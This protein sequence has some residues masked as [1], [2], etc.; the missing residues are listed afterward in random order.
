MHLVGELI[1]STALPL[2]WH[3]SD[4]RAWQT[5]ADL[6]YP[7]NV[8]W[9]I[10]SEL[11]WNNSSY[12]HWNMIR[13]YM[14][15]SFII[16]TEQDKRK[17]WEVSLWQKEEGTK[18]PFLR[19]SFRNESIVII[20][21]WLMKIYYILYQNKNKEAKATEEERVPLKVSTPEEDVNQ[22]PNNHVSKV[23]T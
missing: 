1:Y 22:T 2:L 17:V 14:Y 10:P 12:C 3:W 13:K 4:I 7:F 15:I 23:Y 18:L 8:I 19:D 6:L 21:W 20:L 9:R 5:T 16:W 11:F